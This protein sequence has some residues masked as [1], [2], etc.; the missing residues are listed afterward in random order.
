V[1]LRL[2]P[3]GFDGIFWDTYE[4]TVEDFFPL[5]PSLLRRRDSGH[6]G[7]RF[8]FCNVYQP[9]DPIRHVAYS[10][11]LAARLQLL[12]ISCQFKAIDCSVTGQDYA[13]CEANPYWL[14]D[15]YLVPHC[16]WCVGDRSAEVSEGE[17]RVSGQ[18]GGDGDCA[19]PN[20]GPND[21]GHDGSRKGNADDGTRARTEIGRVTPRAN[22]DGSPRDFLLWSAQRWKVCAALEGSKCVR[23]ICQD[24][25]GEGTTKQVPK[26]RDVWEA[27]RS[28]LD[29]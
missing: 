29:R 3:D 11:Y 8:S 14:H 4:E 25:S 7:G 6:S 18:F 22:A 23:E 27:T 28:I 19:T 1:L 17:T 24:P 20:A 12:G 16:R 9:H 15:V 2:A 10:L 26:L 5:L 13:M 21:R